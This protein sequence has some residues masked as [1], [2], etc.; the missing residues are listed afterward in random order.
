M[1][2]VTLESLSVT[3]DGQQLVAATVR[4]PSGM[5]LR[6]LN[7][8]G[9]VQSLHVPDARGVL[10][11]VVL[12]YDTPE[13]YLRDTYYVGAI[14]GR[15]A[16]RIANAS[17]LID[18]VPVRVS[19]NQ[20]GHHLH[21]GARGFSTRIW[22][23][24][25]FD[26]PGIRGVVL[27]YVSP[28]G[29]EGFPGTLTARVTYTL[30]DDNVWDVTY[31]ATTDR[32]TPVNLTQHSYFNLAGAGSAL[33]HTLRIDADRYLPVS[34]EQI[35]LGVLAPVTGTAFD[36][37]T[38]RPIRDILA[39]PAMMPHGLDDSFVLRGA[40]T[41]VLRPAAE[42]AHAASGRVLTV[43]TTAPSVHC[44]AAK[45]LVDVP[46]KRGEHYRPHDGICLEAQYLPDSP[47]HADFPSTIVLPGT[48]F[49][50]Q[51]RFA[52]TTRTPS[53]L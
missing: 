53:A 29:D 6:V 17:F 8:G 31:D 47:N 36:L 10:S 22:E 37:R 33:D 7:L 18:G 3:H 28:H 12:G 41:D 51:T 48:P 52:F 25:P 34:G 4:A 27:T 43:S 11:D 24:E 39:A 30:T 23:I 40:T 21:G 15:Y 26:A 1:T 45:Y 19:A 9:V 50:M 20:A 46:G 49:R 16:G 44:Y 38:A 35:P 32:A 13:S 42:L 5:E 14:C 2:T